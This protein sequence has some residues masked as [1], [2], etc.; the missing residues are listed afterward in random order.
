[1]FLYWVLM[2]PSI[3]SHEDAC[4][5]CLLSLVCVCLFRRQNSEAIMNSSC[6][7]ISW[8]GSKLTIVRITSIEKN[9]YPTKVVYL[10]RFNKIIVFCRRGS[11]HPLPHT[12]SQ[13]TAK[14]VK[15]KGNFANLTNK[16]KSL[17]HNKSFSLH[18]YP[19]LLIFFMCYTT[20]N[21]KALICSHC[22]ADF[23]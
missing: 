7:I 6:Q 14:L 16:I 13:F 17:G 20:W 3:N 23:N 4:Q 19:V 1:M 22:R 8:L 12:S 21:P 5:I 10:E 18:H 2:L 15:H 9:L 11:I